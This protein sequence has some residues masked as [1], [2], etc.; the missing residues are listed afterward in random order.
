MSDNVI[1]FTEQI[2]PNNDYITAFMYGL[3]FRENCYTCPYAQKQRVSDITVADYWGLGKDTTIPDG[4]GVSL[5]LPSTEKGVWLFEKAKK[6]MQ[7]E[8]RHVDEAV[9]GNGQLMKPSSRPVERDSFIQEYEKQ[10]EFAYIA[11]LK[12]YR[13]QASFNIRRAKTFRKYSDSKYMLLLAR[14]YY[15]ILSKLL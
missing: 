15:K 10:G 4:L 8:L 14:I 13:R 11:P 3:T 6:Y 5:L 1:P 2:F 9:R 7:W 12:K